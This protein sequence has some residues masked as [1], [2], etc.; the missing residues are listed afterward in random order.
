MEIHSL[1]DHYHGPLSYEPKWN[2]AHFINNP[3]VVP[4]SAMT[5]HDYEIENNLTVRNAPYL[6]HVNQLDSSQ[7]E[8]F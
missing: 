8:D 3:N 4:P 7:V 2:K 6:L 5:M 1:I